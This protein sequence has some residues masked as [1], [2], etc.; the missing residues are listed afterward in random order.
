VNKCLL[1]QVSVGTLT[2]KCTITK[3]TSTVSESTSNKYN[4]ILP[5]GAIAPVHNSRNRKKQSVITVGSRFTKAP[6]RA[7]L[8][9]RILRECF[10]M[11][12]DHHT[13]ILATVSPTPTDIEHT[14]NTLEHVTMMDVSLQEI[15]GTTTVPVLINGAALL[16]SPVETWTNEH[17]SVW[18]AAVEGGRFSQLALP[19]NVTG[20]D[21]LAMNATSISALFAGEI[22]QA[23]QEEEGAAWV[24]EADSN[25]RQD[26]IGRSLIGALRREQ[27][28][29]MLR[30][31]RT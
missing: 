19:P 2:G 14:I 8:L 13:C 4:E 18:L 23:R 24:E 28:A 10:V 17:L 9:T 21:L 15:S 31:K 1:L 11:G 6:Y 26:V 30:T 20:A 29:I 25:R 5:K 22:R 27:H 16:Q 12:A 7:S 3:P